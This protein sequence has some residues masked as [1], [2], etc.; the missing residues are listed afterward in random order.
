M[1]NITPVP[2]QDNVPVIAC[3]LSGDEASTR[4]ERWIQ[5]GRYAGLGRVETEDGLRIRF[6]DE[7]TVEQELRALVSA[8]SSCCAWA[9]WEVHRADGELVMRVSSAP[10]GAAA[11]HAMFGGG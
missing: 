2:S 4:A 9:R 6:R 10:E 8:E 1:V 5:L 11:L 3:G 7:P